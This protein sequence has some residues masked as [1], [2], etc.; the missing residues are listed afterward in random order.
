MER[1]EDKE[2]LVTCIFAA[3]VCVYLFVCVVFISAVKVSV[4]EG[5]DFG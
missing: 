1:M 3:A 5:Q 4:Q 2:D